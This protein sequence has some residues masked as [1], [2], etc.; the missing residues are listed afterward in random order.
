MAVPPG[1]IPVL[2]NVGTPTGPRGG[3]PRKCGDTPT[4][5]GRGH[6]NP[7]SKACIHPYTLPLIPPP[8]PFEDDVVGGMSFRDPLFFE[9]LFRIRSVFEISFRRW[10][11]YPDLARSRPVNTFGVDKK[12]W[13]TRPW[14]RSVPLP[15]FGRGAAVSRKKIASTSA[16]CR[17]QVAQSRSLPPPAARDCALAGPC[18]RNRALSR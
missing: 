16:R 4:G 11:R 18:P 15:P 1:A 13:W 5:T 8:H 9:R 10:F 3:Q 6:Q 2:E 12:S 7:S 14:R 17:A